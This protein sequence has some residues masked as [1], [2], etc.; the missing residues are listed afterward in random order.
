MG[1]RKQYVTLR[2]DDLRNLARKILAMKAIPGLD[3]DKCEQMLMAI[4]I[5]QGLR[6]LHEQE[7]RARYLALPEEEKHMYVE[8]QE[9]INVS[10]FLQAGR[11]TVEEWISSLRA[12]SSGMNFDPEALKRV[13]LDQ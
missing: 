12:S 3:V 7:K 1:D 13:R 9:M 10:Y 4:D 2:T 8:P 11:T 6:A 5:L